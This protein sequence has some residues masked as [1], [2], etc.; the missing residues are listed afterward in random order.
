MDIH[1]PLIRKEKKSSQFFSEYLTSRSLQDTS[2][3]LTF[4]SLRS[5]NR[6]AIRKKSLITTVTSSS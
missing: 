4:Q 1:E 2:P 3:P 6:A 5:R